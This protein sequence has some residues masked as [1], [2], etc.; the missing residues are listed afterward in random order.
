MPDTVPDNQALS[1]ELASDA[2]PSTDDT[3]KE[4]L[5]CHLSR[6]ATAFH[7]QSSGAMFLAEV[8]NVKREPTDTEGPYSNTSTPTPPN[9]KLGAI[10]TSYDKVGVTSGRH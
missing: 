6:D 8:L 2:T 3:I 9:A 1:E 5:G 7:G 10:A 4:E